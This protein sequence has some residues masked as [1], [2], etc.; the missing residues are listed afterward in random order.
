MKIINK[1][2]ANCIMNDNL[3]KLTALFMTLIV[4]LTVSLTS[5]V[6]SK[7]IEDTESQNSKTSI[8]E[9]FKDEIPLNLEGCKD[10]GFLKECVK[11]DTVPEGYIGIYTVEDLYNNLQNTD[12][13]YILMNDLTFTDEMYDKGAAFEGGWDPICDFSGIF[14]GN[15]NVINNLILNTTHEYIG[16]FG[17]VINHD[18]IEKLISDDRKNIGLIKNLG[19]N[20]V[21]I[22]VSTNNLYELNIGTVIGS[23]SYVAGCYANNVKINIDIIKSDN[24]EDIT[25]PLIFVG[26][27]CGKAIMSDSCYSNVDI[28]ITNIN[29][30][31]ETDTI[32]KYINVGGIIGYSKYAV[33]SYYS[34]NITYNNDSDI[35]KQ[36]LGYNSFI[37]N[38]MTEKCY[39]NVIKAIENKSDYKRDARTFTAFFICREL[40]QAQKNY[41]INKNNNTE[42]YYVLESSITIREIYKLESILLKA[43]TEQEFRQI[44][45]NDGVLSGAIGCYKLEEGKT[46]SESEFPTYKFGSVWVMKD[47]VWVMRDG[48]PKLQIFQK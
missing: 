10:I 29:N 37:P 1:K 18:D 4:M 26:G 47:G 25:P 46:Y 30:M 28:K 13:N 7:K 21:T 15:G 20:G 24:S 16:L 17:N 6:S 44:S 2:G 5:C 22:D 35:F 14:D 8:I 23:G 12:K 33:S 3:R 31:Y 9:N 32:H 19:L 38:V 27:I 39:D 48:V 36:A 34:G 45:I 40:Y 41:L 11:Q 42:T 43:Y